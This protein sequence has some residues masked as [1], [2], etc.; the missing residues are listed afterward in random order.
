MEDSFGRCHP[1][2]NLSYFTLALLGAM[3]LRHSLCQGLSLAVAVGYLIRLESWPTVR[4]RAKC[5]MPLLV[6]SALINPAFSHAGVT[7][8]AWFPTGNPL[9]L[10]SIWFGISAAVTLAAALGWCFCASAV[11]TT[12]KI[13]C[14][15]GRC[16]PAV[17][18]LLSMALRFL[19]RLRRQI[20]EIRR[21]QACLPVKGGRLTGRLRRGAQLCSA[22]VTWTLENAVVTADSMRSRGYG[23]PG[24]TAFSL[25]RF[26]AR[27]WLLLTMQLLLAAG[28]TAAA[29]LGQLK[30][31]YYPTV[32][33]A[34]GVG[35]WLGALAYGVLLLQPLILDWKEGRTWRRLYSNI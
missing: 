9:T 14:L 7:V 10:E 8:L 23:L 19:P 32:G 18:L 33:G 6:L 17:G 21:A 20:G 34:W 3:A 1:A 26:D 22:L 35:T 4:H 13:V 15:L 27:D 29:V 31:Y 5:L 30:W 28:T 2:V 24:R 16:L 12:D 25:Y 11:L